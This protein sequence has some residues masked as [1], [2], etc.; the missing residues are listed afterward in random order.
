MGTLLG[1]VAQAARNERLISHVHRKAVVIVRD[2][3]AIPRKD[4]QVVRFESTMGEMIRKGKAPFMRFETNRRR[5]DAEFPFFSARRSRGSNSESF[6]TPKLTITYK[7]SHFRR[8]QPEQDE[9]RALSLWLGDNKHIPS[10]SSYVRA[11]S[12]FDLCTI[13]ELVPI[14]VNVL[15]SFVGKF[16]HRQIQRRQSV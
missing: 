14:P 6:G 13:T 11:L 9:R 10:P 4:W 8:L 7:E 1:E 2:D 16:Q 5:F 3:Q 15:R 12:I